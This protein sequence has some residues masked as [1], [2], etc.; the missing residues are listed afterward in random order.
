MVRTIINPATGLKRRQLHHEVNRR[1]RSR[2]LS[3]EQRGTLM[4][5][6][7]RILDTLQATQM[8]MTFMVT[9]H[10]ARQQ[11]LGDTKGTETDVSRALS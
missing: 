9:S 11:I 5:I 2:C 6:K 4:E 7:K 1:V 10:V 8:G 3:V